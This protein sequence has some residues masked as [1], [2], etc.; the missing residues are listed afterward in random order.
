MNDGGICIA[1]YAN[2]L[3]S[4]TISSSS[5]RSLLCLSWFFF[6][7]CLS[8]QIFSQRWL[9]KKKT[10]Q[11]TKQNEILL[12]FSRCERSSLLTVNHGGKRQRLWQWFNRA[13]TFDDTGSVS[14]NVSRPSKGGPSYEFRRE[15]YEWKIN[16]LV[17]V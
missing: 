14:F 8:K 4:I 7:V 13:K 6:L 11:K 16:D 2:D 17:S 10:K 3:F 12:H 5:S 1:M 9:I 15:H